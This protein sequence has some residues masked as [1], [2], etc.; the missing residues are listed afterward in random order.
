MLR[1]HFL[2]QIR[3]AFATHPVVALLGPRQSGK[4]TLARQLASE[5][6]RKKREVIFFD[7]EDATDLSRFEH[8][9]ATLSPLEG[10]VVIDEVQQ[11]PELFKTLRV[12]VDR[13]PSQA[14]RAHFLVLGSAP[15]N[16]LR[17]GSETLA[18]RI[19]S[20]HPRERLLAESLY[21]NLLRTGYP[22]FGIAHSASLPAAVLD[23]VGPLPWADLQ[24]LRDQSFF[25]RHRPHGA[26]L[27]RCSCRDLHGPSPLPV[28]RKYF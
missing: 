8:P 24:R 5:E 18:G 9:Q 1:S 15:W 28:G 25:G 7:L 14:K 3:R 26:P 20:R 22:I 19:G 2:Q 10:L 17:Q 16:L 27:S 6:R 4:T 12:L 13:P 21:Q 11:A 23:D